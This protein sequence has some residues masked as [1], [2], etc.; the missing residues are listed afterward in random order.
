ME[1]SKYTDIINKKFTKLTPIELNS[2]GQKIRYM[3][4]CDCGN[5]I[6]VI[7]YKLLTGH[8]KSCGCLVKTA[9]G[10]LN[11]TH[12]RSNDKIYKAWCQMRR[13]CTKPTD[14]INYPN[15]GGRGIKVCERWN[16]FELFLKD[17]GERPTDKHSIERIDNNGDYEPKNCR[18]AT[19]KE[20]N[21]NKRNNAYITLVEGGQEKQ[22]TYAQLTE[23]FGLEP[24]MFYKRRRRGWSIA[25]A[26]MIPHRK[27]VKTQF[28][29]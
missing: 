19:R 10:N 2:S 21:S 26:L 14:T 7:R 29:K 24:G 13:K 23:K 1:T 9:I 11:R 27:V 8:V 18:W 17:M 5:T 16:N 25:Q 22:Y 20:Q 6:E 4:R 12:G 3:C 28:V 15:Y